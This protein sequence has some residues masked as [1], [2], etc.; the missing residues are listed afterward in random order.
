MATRDYKQALS[1]H[2]ESGRLAERLRAA[3]MEL[4]K[5]PDAP[6]L[7]DLGSLD[8]F[9]TGGRAATREL[10]RAAALKPETRV[11]DVGGGMGG[12]ARTLAEEFGC[13]VTVLEPNDEFREVGE[14]L[15]AVTRLSERVFFKSGDALDIPFEDETFD[16]V[17]TQNSSMNIEDKEQLYREFHRVLRAGGRLALQEIMAGPLS[18]AHY[19]TA[20]ATDSSMSFLRPPDECR[21]LLTGVGFRELEW[22]NFSETGSVPGQQAPQPATTTPEPSVGVIVFGEE[23]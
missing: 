12:P 14:W 19:P 20:W 7:D 10:A 4:G 18:P 16:C 17:W 6:T 23:R 15:T 8:Q 2:Y 22:T 3:L 21:S 9:H 5:N 13:L 1:R 11:L